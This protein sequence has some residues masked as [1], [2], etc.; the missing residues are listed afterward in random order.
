[1]RIITLLLLALLLTGTGLSQEKKAKP[2]I[3]FTQILELLNT[4][5]VSLIK[6]KALVLGYH[7][8][9]GSRYSNGSHLFEILARSDKSFM[10]SENVNDLNNR[11]QALKQQ[12]L[13]L[14]GEIIHDVDYSIEIAI[15]GFVFS[16]DRYR[17]I[18]I[19]KPLD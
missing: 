2:D 15:N 19:S 10:Y 11:W 1:M 6:K 4:K 7:P 13:D 12:A 3:T 17:Y 16:T 9:T 18:R 8:V 5:T 14:G